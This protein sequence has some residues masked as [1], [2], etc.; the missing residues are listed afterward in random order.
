[1]TT[2]TLDRET[3]AQTRL[4]FIDCDIHPTLRGALDNLLPYLEKRWHEHLRLYGPLMHQALAKTL[5]YPR[6]QPGLARLDAWPP[7]G[8][9]PGS[10]LAF[11]RR[12]HL[13]PNGVEFGMLQ[14][15]GP[16]P[17]Q[18]N[19][20]FGAALCTA[21]NEWQ[22]QEWTGQDKRLRGALVVMP[23]NPDAAIAEIKR[24]GAD[25]SFAQIAFPPRTADP[26]GHRRYWPIYELAAEYDLPIGMHA[27]GSNG[28]TL[29]GG[30]WPSFY[31]EDHYSNVQV[32]Q[33]VTT[34]FVLEGV[35]ERFPTLKVVLI[36]GGF[37]WVPALTWRLDK[38]WSR[39]RSEVP[40]VKRPPSEYIK[41]NIWFTTQPIEEPEKPRDLLHLI[42]W[43]GWDRLL[44]STDYPHWDFDDPKYVLKVRL[45][46]KQKAQLFRGNARDVYSRLG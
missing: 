4:T 17:T 19:L 11:M 35:F 1:M 27:S 5:S 12:Q 6:M 34:S 2:T 45:T 9:A 16:G 33:A 37:G 38:H 25:R 43:I 29:T 10:S 8:G 46:D 39:L 36:E 40:Q 30:G 42:D 41:S 13:D 7:E 22:L 32:M 14:P 15:I 23:D 20:D 21:F 24:Y 26:P 18:R 44:F 3:E 31:L 28:H